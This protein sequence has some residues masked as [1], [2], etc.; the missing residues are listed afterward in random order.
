MDQTLNGDLAQPPG[1]HSPVTAPS[2]AVIQVET[3][4]RSNHDDERD[5]DLE[6]LLALGGGRG[7]AGDGE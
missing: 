3:A 5:S 6:F 4:G 1:R 7:I 2:G